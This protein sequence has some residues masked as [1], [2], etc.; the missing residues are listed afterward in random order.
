MEEIRLMN[1]WKKKQEEKEKEGS[2][3]NDIIDKMRIDPSK[4]R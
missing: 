2:A 4:L 1:E 3:K